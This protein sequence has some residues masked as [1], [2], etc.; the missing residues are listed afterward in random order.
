MAYATGGGGKSVKTSGTVGG[1]GEVDT[2]VT[3]IK[4]G[5]NVTLTS[6]ANKVVTIASTGGGGSGN[7]L[8]DAYDQGG[9]GAGRTIT[10][11]N[12]A[13][14]LNAVGS[15]DEILR[16]DSNDNNN[17]PII[18]KKDSDITFSVGNYSGG[19]IV[20]LRGNLQKIHEVS[21][22]V[23]TLID[24]TAMDIMC[25]HDGNYFATAKGLNSAL[26]GGRVNKIG[27][28]TGLPETGNTT[29]QSEGSN[30]VR[31]PDAIIVGGSLNSILSQDP[32]IPA[33]HCSIIGGYRNEIKDSPAG[34]GTIG[35]DTTLERSAT[36]CAGSAVITNA[37]DS[38]AI[39]GISSVITD[40]TFAT[41]IGSNACTINSASGSQG[42][43]KH[44]AIIASEGSTISTKLAAPLSGDENANFGKTI[45][46]IASRA[47]SV[48]E[49]PKNCLLV[50]DGP[51]ATKSTS[52]G[53]R[54]LSCIILG[55]GGTDTDDTH[56][57]SNAIAL[58]GNSYSTVGPALG[59]GFADVGWVATGADFAE[60]FEWNDGNPNEEDRV[61]LFVKLS[62]SNSGV[63]N[64][65]IE[66]GGE[67][68][69]GPVS[70]MPGFVSNA[71]TLNWTGKWQK[72]DFG[73]FMFDDDGNRILNPNFDADAQYRAREARKEWSPIGMTGRLRV[74][75]SSNIG[76]YPSNKSGLTVNVNP[77]GTVSD[78]GSKG[79]YKV[80]QV[81]KQ[82]EI[83]SGPEGVFR[84]RRQIQDH[85]YGVVEIL[86]V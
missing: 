12:G 84:R 20:G 39:G 50:G 61:G 11:D 4:A 52:T 71:P 54:D 65:K 9:S 77:D 22:Q 46:V 63:P 27:L 25:N 72:D 86:V 57:N 55:G 64:G 85:G 13:I 75:A 33:D 17:K 48:T 42:A 74:K 82:K 40:Q 56:T 28:E 32:A 2:H 34:R 36:V 5:S 79:K 49:D 35:F 43:G 47:A 6:D 19:S 31:A 67:N 18:V 45:A 41:I 7:T 15:I 29:G 38:I 16:I 10:V 21:G 68:T 81:V 59:V 53:Y 66:V 24:P 14:V 3:A 60:Y 73:R 62:L 26:V 44:N 23:I 1:S 58:V 37:S 70:A 30:S 8:D 51:T 83:W 76:V 78:A 69:I 80:I